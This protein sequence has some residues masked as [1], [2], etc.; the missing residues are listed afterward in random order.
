[1]NA[2]KR[3]LQNIFKSVRE[4]LLTLDG[5]ND[6]LQEVLE[7]VQ[8][9]YVSLFHRSTGFFARQQ[10]NQSLVDVPDVTGTAPTT[11]ST[12]ESSKSAKTTAT[13]GLGTGKPGCQRKQKVTRRQEHQRSSKE[14]VSRKRTAETDASRK[15][16]PTKIAPKSK[17][18][19]SS[20]TKTPT[21]ASRKHTAP[22]KTPPE[23]R[24]PLQ[25]QTSW[26][27]GHKRVQ[28]IQEMCGAGK[29][30]PPTSD[31]LH[32]F[33]T[34]MD[35]WG[36]LDGRLTQ[37]LGSIWNDCVEASGDPGQKRFREQLL[38]VLS[39]PNGVTNCIQ[40]FAG[41]MVKEAVNKSRGNMQATVEKLQDD[42][43]TQIYK[44]YIDA[45]TKCACEK[46]KSVVEFDQNY[47]R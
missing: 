36:K 7:V 44:E 16:P 39:I 2:S 27:A 20:S 28:M 26:P 15:G 13:K 4:N 14:F 35:N 23:P 30:M 42:L 40:H 6:T 10:M 34:L 45:L 1:M 24:R 37:A 47:N 11:S 38:R 17:P 21:T 8:Q 43:N 18:T 9:F 3:Y 19:K 25:M 22:K 33:W 12:G 41:T 32:L 29:D 5:Q 46:C 31:E